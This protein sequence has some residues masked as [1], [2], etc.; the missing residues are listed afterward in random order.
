[1]K[2]EEAI[3]ELRK[4]DKRKFIQTIDLN[5]VLKNIDLKNP[6]NRFSKDVALPHGRGKN[7]EV[8]IIS[9]TIPDAITK[10]E[11][12]SL[13]KD[14]KRMREIINKYH[15]FLCDPPLMVV[16]GKVLGKYLG[17]RGKMPK[18]LP[19]NAPVDKLVENLKK[20]IVVKAIETPTLNIPIGVE[21]MSDDEIKENA[22]TVLRE[23]KSQLPSGSDQIKSIIIKTTMGKPVKLDA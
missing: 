9:D 10:D 3:Q 22:S 11:L 13:P 14:K 1:M 5:V 21:S 12:E 4:Q 16:V 6:E 2:L 17:P 23:V 7:I 19:P 8:G 18:P 20:S 15:Y